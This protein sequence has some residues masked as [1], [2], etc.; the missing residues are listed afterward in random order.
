MRI[1]FLVV[2]LFL[3]I[4]GFAQLEGLPKTDDVLH[5]FLEVEQLEVAPS[6]QRVLNFVKRLEHNPEAYG[7]H[8][9]QFARQLFVKTHS[10]FLKT[11]RDDASFSQLFSNG[12]YNCLTATALLGVVLQ[13]FDYAFKIFETNHHIFILVETDRGTALLET[14]DPFDGFTTDP[15]T[16]EKK[17]TSYKASTAAATDSRVIQYQFKTALYHEVSLEQLTGL[18]HF[19]IAAKAYNSKNYERAITHLEKATV[20]YNSSRVNEFTE[21]ILLT[22][23]EANTTHANELTARLQKLQQLSGQTNSKF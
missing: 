11:F 21:V 16:I 14:T 10:R 4:G 6:T 7:N 20:N 3:P 19:N 12:N 17:I 23:K 13:H 15:K 9:Q 8:Q 5:R 22:L 1:K 18:L 2:I